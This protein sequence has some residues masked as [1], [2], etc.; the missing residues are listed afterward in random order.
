MFLGYPSFWGLP[1]VGSETQR[2]SNYMLDGCFPGF[3]LLPLHLVYFLNPNF[4]IFTSLE[5]KIVFDRPIKIKGSF[6]K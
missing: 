2:A 1:R 3:L 5:V 4:L 6:V